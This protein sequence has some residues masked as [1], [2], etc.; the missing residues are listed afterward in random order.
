MFIIMP[1][2]TAYEKGFPHLATPIHEPIQHFRID[3]TMFVRFTQ[4]HKDYI[5]KEFGLKPTA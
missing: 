2:F 3:R 1:V 4:V 5:A